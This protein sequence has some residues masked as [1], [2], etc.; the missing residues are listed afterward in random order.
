VAGPAS[1]RRSFSEWRRDS[2]DRLLLWRDRL[3]FV[4]RSFALAVIT[5][6][7]ILAW[8]ELEP[9][10]APRGMER[11]AAQVV[12]VIAQTARDEEGFL[13]RRYALVLEYRDA[14]GET[15]RWRTGLDAR[16]HTTR[17]GDRVDIVYGVRDPT[18][19]SLAPSQQPYLIA[20][21]ALAVAWL[22]LASFLIWPVFTGRAP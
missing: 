19:V 21:G 16:H 15:R 6:G 5:L 7:A 20:R 22:A 9:V 8:W 12:E 4:W 11:T 2:Y 10:E 14:G 18:I 3:P 1:P 13:R 17:V